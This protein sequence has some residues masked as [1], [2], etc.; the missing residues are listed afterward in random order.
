MSCFAAIHVLFRLLP[1]VL[2]PVHFLVTDDAKRM[3]GV[4][5][6]SNVVLPSRVT[7]FSGAS[8]ADP[9]AEVE[10]FDPRLQHIM[11]NLPFCWLD[12]RGRQRFTLSCI[13]P[14]GTTSRSITYKFA[15]DGMSVF[16]FWHMPIAMCNHG[17]VL[18]SQNAKND[19]QAKYLGNTY[20][21][22]AC[23]KAFEDAKEQSEPIQKASK[24]WN[25]QVG[26]S[27]WMTYDLP[28]RCL[29]HL[30]AYDDEK[31]MRI[32]D[33]EVDTFGCERLTT[34]IVF[35]MMA[36][37]QKQDEEEAEDLTMSVA[38]L[39]NQKRRANRD[40]NGSSGKNRRTGS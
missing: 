31:G 12:S 13:P 32:M 16:F 35:E 1:I 10:E 38:D 7:S 23:N 15:P 2:S 34:V 24:P 37:E 36:A 11:P 39:V 30:V 17:F 14:G 29:P 4:T 5:Q 33:K 28:F 3:V 21:A 6:P 40:D 27:Y 8:F 20:R 26:P 19:E 9:V 22:I 18:S 25:Y